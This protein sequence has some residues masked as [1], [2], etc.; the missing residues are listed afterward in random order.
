[1]KV[2]GLV[3]AQPEPEFHEISR[4]EVASGG[5]KKIRSLPTDRNGRPQG[6]DSRSYMGDYSGRVQEY[7]PPRKMEQRYSESDR[8]EISPRDRR[9]YVTGPDRRGSDR[10]EFER[11]FSS[12][13]YEPT[14]LR[15]IENEP[16]TTNKGVQ[17]ETGPQ[18]LK[19]DTGDKGENGTSIILHY[20]NMNLSPEDFRPVMFFSCFSMLKGISIV[21]D[22]SSTTEYWLTDKETGRLI[23]SFMNSKHGFNHFKWDNGNNLLSG[24]I[25][26]KAKGEGDIMCVQVYI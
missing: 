12:E 4:K 15:S 1:M 14:P 11:H 25:E 22:T 21:S 17:G 16:K 3:V 20:P 23:D 9:E 26:L 7:S 8:R 19:G 6:V 2:R 18:G 5:A 24:V 10:R 13:T